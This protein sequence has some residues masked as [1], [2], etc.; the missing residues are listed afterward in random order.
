MSGGRTWE[1]TTYGVMPS[2]SLGDPLQPDVLVVSTLD[3]PGGFCELH[4]AGRTV[5]PEECQK[6]VRRLRSA[7][8]ATAHVILINGEA[9]DIPNVFHYLDNLSIHSDSAA[10]LLSAHT[11]RPWREHIAVANTSNMTAYLPNAAT[12]IGE[13]SESSMRASSLLRPSIR[14]DMHWKTDVL[15]NKSGEVAYLYYRCDR[16]EREEFF[17]LLVDRLGSKRVHALGRCRGNRVGPSQHS[18]D[19]QRYHH[20][21]LSQAISLLSPFKFVIAFENAR[22]YGYITEKLTNAYL[23]HT[24]PIYFGAPD[25][26]DIFSADSMIN[27]NHFATLQDCA[28]RVA[29]LSANEVEYAN[30]LGASPMVNKTTWCR[31][32]QSQRYVSD[33]CPH[34]LTG[35]IV[36][37]IRRSFDTRHQMPQP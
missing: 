3:G 18:Y 9:M 37:T 12:S 22:R 19:Q 30:V 4:V 35:D 29:K 20:S 32:F 10:V 7:V 17:D 1:D 6:H 13:L 31:F 34:F 15:R 25:V 36:G 21:Y 16:P 27:C 14:S 8:S 2:E 28:D 26:N 33:E 5:W 11:D 24:V 23:A